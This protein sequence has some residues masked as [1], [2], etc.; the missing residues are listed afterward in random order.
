[1]ED[2][3][4][5]AMLAVHDFIGGC[6]ELGETLTA[7]AALATEAIGVDEA[8]LTLNEADGRVK[9]VVYTDKVVTEIDEAQYQSDRGPCLEACRR[10]EVILVADIGVDAKDEWPEFATSAVSHGVHSSASLPIV[11]GN[12]GI[13]AL[14]FYDHRVGRFDA[15]R[16]ALARLFAGQ[17][18]VVSAFYEKAEAADHLKRA[19]ESRATIEQAKGVIIAAAG[20]S[21][22]E[23]FDILRIQSQA[24]N[25][26]LR[27]V[28][29]ELIELQRRRQR[30]T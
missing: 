23:A 17:A 5:L 20:C 30:P 26:K 29:A 9:T 2:R 7:I 21:P 13:G 10:G 11:V 16:V 28:A 3:L 8:G 6:R 27:D 14:N 15:Q 22:D 18:A 25:R 12:T 24:E 1:M 4:G 19:M